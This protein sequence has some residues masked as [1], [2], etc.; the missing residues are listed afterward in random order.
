MNDADVT[1]MLDELAAGDAT[2]ALA[3][4][5]ALADTADPR[6]ELVSRLAV[7]VRDS[8]S[9]YATLAAR[10]MILALMSK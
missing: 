5:D 1:R 3:L 10:A 7:R 6:A 9:F 2:A 4:A 8:K